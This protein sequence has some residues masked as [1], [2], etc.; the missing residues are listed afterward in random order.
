LPN[1]DDINAAICQGI[2]ERTRQLGDR[3]PSGHVGQDI[4]PSLRP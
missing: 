1:P 2:E 3:R 4:R